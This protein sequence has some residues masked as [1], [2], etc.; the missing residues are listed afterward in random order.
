MAI[1]N[2][3][4]ITVKGSVDFT[5]EV[6]ATFVVSL[7]SPTPPTPTPTPPTPTPTPPT[8]TPTPTPLPTPTPTP[9]PDPGPG[10]TAELSVCVEY[11][12]T[13]FWYHAD[14]GIDRGDWIDQRG[15]FVQNRLD[16]TNAE[17]PELRVQ[18]RCDR[19]GTRDEVVFELGD[20]TAGTK[21]YNM[22]SYTATIYRGTDVLATVDVPEHYWYSRW[23][24]QSKPRPIVATTLELQDADLLPHFDMELSTTRPLSPTRVY[25][26]MGLA[27]LTAYVPSTG[28]RDEIGLVTEAQAEYLRGDAPVDSLIAQAEASGTMPWHY[29]NE[30]GGAVFNFIEHPQATLYGP[31][32]PWIATP[33]TLDVAHEPDL[34]YVPFLLTGDPYYLEELQFAAT[35]NVLASNPQSRGNYCIGF[36]TRAHAWA[37]RTLAHCARMTP[38]NAPAWVQP[39]AY[40]KDWHDGNR[41]W[42]LNRYVHPTAA[43]FTASP[44]TI[45]HYMA[46]ATNSPGSSTMP[47]GT[48]SQQWMEDYEAAVLGHV[49]AIGYGDWLPILE[50]KLANSIARTNG[51]SGWVRAKPT[52]YNVALRATD[53]SPYVQSWQESWDLNVTMQPDIAEFDDPDIIP[54]GDSLVYASYT[55][56]AL[57]IAAALGIEG[58][59][60]CY[61]WLRSQLVANSDTKTYVD[62][63]WSMGS[64]DH[65]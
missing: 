47:A 19:D 25:E 15:A 51:T 50:W 62:R 42:M 16:A 35:Y 65:V 27:G 38:D 34:G 23:R 63:K 54:A 60:D 9:P 18:F 14:D 21:A 4:T 32:I 22:T 40:W 43:P 6:D 46:D 3:V 10:P 64:L 33:I 30:D 5:G 29:R 20:T 56:S 36:A 28:E 61:E 45:L 7:S 53:K 11:N 52:P 59:T 31:T 26:P 1:T 8:P 48:V 17:L 13:E 39:R 57:A 44:Y 41:D 55:M 2:D 24:W 12:D 49:V 37:L 58:A